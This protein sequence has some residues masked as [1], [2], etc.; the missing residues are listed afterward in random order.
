MEG[1]VLVR[2]GDAL[3]EDENVQEGV[4]WITLVTELNRQTDPVII[5]YAGNQP[6]MEWAYGDV[7]PV[8]RIGKTGDKLGYRHIERLPS[9]KDRKKNCRPFANF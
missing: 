4:E 9:W 2:F 7:C 6:A 3:F 1:G 8:V 5:W